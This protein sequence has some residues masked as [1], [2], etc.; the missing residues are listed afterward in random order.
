MMIEEYNDVLQKLHD[1]MLDENN[2]QKSLRM[3]INLNKDL[4]EKLTK[5][6]SVN[7]EQPQ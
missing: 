1:Y 5:T 6:Q 4:K 2:I 3:K 7:K